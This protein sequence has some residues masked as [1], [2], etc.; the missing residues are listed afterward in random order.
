LTYENPDYLNPKFASQ[1]IEIEGGPSQE[2]QEAN[3]AWGA[4]MDDMYDRMLA[5][6]YWSKGDR[7]AVQQILARNPNVGIEYNRVGFGLPSVSGS[8]FGMEAARVLN[9]LGTLIDSG[10]LFQI[11]APESREYAHAQRGH[12]L[13]DQDEWEKKHITSNACGHMA[14]VAQQQANRALRQTHGNASAALSAFDSR[15]AKIYAGLP[16]NSIAN[17]ID[18]WNNGPIHRTIGSRYLGETGF[19][20]RF[21]DTDAAEL[22]KHGDADQTHHFAA[23]FS[24][25]INSTGINWLSSTLHN[26]NDNDGDQRLTNAAYDLGSRLASDPGSLKKIGAMIRSDICDPKTRGKHF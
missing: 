21:M 23:M 7:D 18:L 10:D 16:M 6:F 20:T 26:R 9:A 17:A 1:P 2:Y 3:A 12:T 22:A 15:F 19:K 8:V 25:G 5:E 4:A 14:A 11:G 24:T 13:V